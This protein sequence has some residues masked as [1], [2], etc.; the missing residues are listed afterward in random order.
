MP[1]NNCPALPPLAQAEIVVQSLHEPLCR[2]R[3]I[4]L[5]IARLDLIDTGVS[6]NKWFKLHQNLELARQHGCRR[7]VSFGGPWSNHIHALADAG[8]RFG[9]ATVGIIRGYEALPLTPT[10]TDAR[11]WGMQLEFVDH[12]QYRLKNDADWLSALQRRFEPCMIV[13]EGGSNS[14]GVAGCGQIMAT[15]EDAGFKPDTAV[16]ACGTGATLAGILQ[17]P[18]QLQKVLGVSVLKGDTEVPRRVYSL[19][20]GQINATLDWDIDTEHHYGGYARTSGTLLGFI[21]WFYQ[22]HNII[23]EPVYSGKMMAALYHRLESGWFAPGEQV[24]AIHCGGLQG[25]RGYRHHW[26]WAEARLA[27]MQR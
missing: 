14:A 16:L 9:F 11:R 17:R 24:M 15:I 7:I 23:L 13:P 18:G 6:G 26:P 1:S 8:R 20:A 19:A 5:A 22:R 25:L 21:E 10:L 4:E 27:A 2:E 3:G 12:A